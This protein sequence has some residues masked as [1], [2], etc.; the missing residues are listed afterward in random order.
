MV[1]LPDFGITFSR[2]AIEVS[3]HPGERDCGVSTLRDL[4]IKAILEALFPSRRAGLWCF[5]LRR[6]HVVGGYEEWCFHPGERDCGVSTKQ[7][8]V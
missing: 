1:F 6:G 5:Y 8:K 2:T 3:F 4:S 7:E